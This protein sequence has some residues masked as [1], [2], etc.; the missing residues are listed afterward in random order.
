MILNT[1]NGAIEEKITYQDII[2]FKKISNKNDLRSELIARYKLSER[3]LKLATKTSPEDDR[4]SAWHSA[5][6]VRMQLYK[7]GK[8]EEAVLDL[9][10]SEA[11]RS[12][13]FHLFNALTMN[14]NYDFGPKREAT[15]IEVIDF[16]NSK[17]SPCRR[18]IFRTG[19]GK[20]CN[21]TSKTPFAYQGT[22][23][24]MGD[25]YLKTAANLFLTDPDASVQYAKK[26]ESIYNRVDWFIFKHKAK[27]W[28]MFKHVEERKELASGLIHGENRTD[29]YFKTRPF[30]DI[31]TCTSCH[32]DGRDKAALHLR[33]PDNK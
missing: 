6:L 21:T 12:P 14:S 25:T 15:L 23:V 16:M 24:Y 2:Q 10:T 28:K 11:V 33:L 18:L 30:L 3:F 4:I 8:V 9:I 29:G 26:A 20:K 27:R 1:N 5:N 17:E 13:V 22:T 32:Q 19:E 31:Y 7:D